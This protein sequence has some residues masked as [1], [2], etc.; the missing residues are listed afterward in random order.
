MKE[1]TLMDIVALLQ[2]DDAV[3][4]ATVYFQSS[5]DQIVTIHFKNGDMET[6]NCAGYRDTYVL[7]RIGKL[8]EERGEFR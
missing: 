8:F 5:V 2:E 4:S 6:L 3:R 7:W 1:E